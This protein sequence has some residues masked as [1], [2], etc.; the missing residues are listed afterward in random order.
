MPKGS[1]KKWF[2]DADNVLTLQGKGRAKQEFEVASVIKD[3]KSITDALIFT[4]VDG[5]YN[6]G[7]RMVIFVN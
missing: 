6:A 4:K 3:N 5:S 2:V 7:K 1:D